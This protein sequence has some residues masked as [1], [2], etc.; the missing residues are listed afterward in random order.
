MMQAIYLRK[1][2]SLKLEQSY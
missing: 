1:S 2:T